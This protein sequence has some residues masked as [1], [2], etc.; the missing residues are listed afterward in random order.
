MSHEPKRN[1][2]D[3]AISLRGIKLQ[4]DVHGVEWNKETRAFAI[5][6]S[7]VNAELNAQI[8][9]LFNLINPS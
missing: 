7:E 2:T 1:E 5:H 3:F 8:R 4:M 9:A 6:Q